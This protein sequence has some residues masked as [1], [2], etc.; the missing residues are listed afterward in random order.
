MS[1]QATNL[2]Q[3]LERLDE[4]AAE[5]DEVSAKRIMEAVGSRSFGPLLLTAGLILATPLS[6]IPGLPTTVS[7]FVLLIAIQ[8]LLRKRHFWLPAWVLKRSVR[9]SRFRAALKMLKWPAAMVDKPLRP[10]LQRLTHAGG[11]R[12]VAVTCLLI[13]P[14]APLLELIPFAATGL[15]VALAA[16]GLSL[17]A[18][19]GLLILLAYTLTVT[20]AILA[21]HI[22]T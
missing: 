2:E 19:D 6:G 5:H 14:I 17:I 1:E 11:S 13:A 9:S 20:V 12:M 21:V 15:G 3:L 10:R 4:A 18:H 8:L 16:F 22:L 7:L